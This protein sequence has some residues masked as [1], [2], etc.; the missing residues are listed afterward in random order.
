MPNSVTIGVIAALNQ[1]RY[2][3]RRSERPLARAVRT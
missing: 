2:M 3:T 1:R